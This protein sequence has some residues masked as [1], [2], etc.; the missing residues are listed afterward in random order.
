MCPY[1]DKLTAWLLGD[2]SP[3][4]HEA[5]TRH[6]AACAEC[7]NARDEL[8]AVLTPLR[9]GLA[10]DRRLFRDGDAAARPSAAGRAARHLTALLHAPWLRAAAIVLISFGALFALI[11]LHYHHAT[12]RMEPVGPVTTF[13]FHKRE[14]PPEPLETLPQPIAA[15]DTLPLAFEPL[16][17][18][19]PITGVTVPD[20]PLYSYAIP[21]TFLTLQLPPWEA[22]TNALSYDEQ[23]LVQ[24]QQSLSAATNGATIILNP[25]PAIHAQ[26][27]QPRR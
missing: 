14:Q 23:L 10:K 11:S 7:R 1:E 25:P 17:L 20:A 16:T 3:Q 22:P 18:L 9:T 15:H 13:T 19:P 4:E 5:V 24:Q 21:H 26:P 8:A 2:L 27:R 6:L 12:S